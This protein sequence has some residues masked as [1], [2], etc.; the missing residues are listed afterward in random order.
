MNR[1]RARKSMKKKVKD[2]GKQLE[3]EKKTRDRQTESERQE[4]LLPMMAYC[5]YNNVR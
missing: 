5:S 1:W 4:L 3:Y 2:I